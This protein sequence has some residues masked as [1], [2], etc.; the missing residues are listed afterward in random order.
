[1]DS[2][3]ITSGAAGEGAPLAIASRPA[4]R[5]A[6]SAGLHAKRI[7]YLDGWRGVSLI[8]VL[9][10]HFL[11][12]AGFKTGPLGVE[13]FFV[14]SGRL[15]AE[16]LFVEK[17][18][19]KTFYARRFSRIYPA[20]AV[21]VAIIFFAFLPTALRFKPAFVFS[22]LTF[23]YNYFAANGHRADPVDHIWS[24]CVE[25]H[26]YLLLGLFALLARARPK[27]A[28]VLIAGLAL[29]SMVDGA[30]SD[31]VFRQSWFNA[32][33]RTDSHIASVLLPAVLYMVTR[34]GGRYAIG[35]LPAWLAPVC[36]LAG[37]ALFCEAVDYGVS[38]TLGASLLAVA[39]CA[40]DAA[41]AWL[42]NG[43]SS[44]V[45]TRAGV[46]SYSVYLWQQPFYSVLTH[47][48]HTLPRAL[49]LLAGAVAA[50]VA[51]FHLLERPAR[52]FL[53]RVLTG[54]GHGQARFG[55]TQVK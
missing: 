23:S 16:I 47:G 37:A 27:T 48:P 49:P 5:E 18:P 54:A 44:R 2:V 12:I 38:Y 30:V 55:L 13:L 53:N 41:P 17:A 39:V 26:A 15:M 22:D 20:M 24:L 36:G 11:P 14:L 34:R 50:G 33:W 10:G 45:L 46:L 51:S 19:L 21:C 7:R 9:I 52:Q 1:V 32:Y 43:L 42:R 35:R 3:G 4:G 8:C 29:A 31:L 40:V 6:V 25:E 28:A